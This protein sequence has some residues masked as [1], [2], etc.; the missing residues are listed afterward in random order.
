[1]K[2]YEC[3]GKLTKKKGKYKYDEC[4]LDN[5]LLHNITTHRCLKCGEVEVE[6]PCMEEL[7]MLIGI[8]LVFK[9]TGLIGREAK[10]LRKNMG[11]TADELGGAVGVER[12]TVTRWESAKKMLN[13]DRDKALRLFYTNKKKDDFLKMPSIE[14][15]MRALVDYLPVKDNPKYQMRSEDWTACATQ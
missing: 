11:Y 7:N 14:P 8:M 13:S 10:Y 9:P 5:V 6:I 1:M 2:C 15:L 12:L 3:D 4:G